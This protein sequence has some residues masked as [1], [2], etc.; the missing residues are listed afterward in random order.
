[1]D[2]LWNVVDLTLVKGCGHVGKLDMMMDNLDW[3]ISLIQV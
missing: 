3:L 1:M 2:Q